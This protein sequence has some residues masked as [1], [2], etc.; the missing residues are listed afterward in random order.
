METKEQRRYLRAFDQMAWGL[1]EA[2]FTQAGQ[3]REV[4][5]EDA[6]EDFLNQLP[7]LPQLEKGHVWKEN[8]VESA[9]VL[10][11]HR[12]LRKYGFTVPEI[13]KVVEAYYEKLLR[14]QPMLFRLVMR[15]VASS[16]IFRRRMKKWAAVTQDRSCP[17]G[18]VF[19]YIPGDGKT[20]TYG[21]DVKECA[22]CK[23]YQAQGEE[24]LI[25]GV[26]RLDYVLDRVIGTGLVR[27]GTLGEG[28]S[29]CDFRFTRGV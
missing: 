26:C 10:A 8:L 13:E 11:L 21:L 2:L 27:T 6:R 28:Q 16:W 14:S 7:R 3:S 22:I 15:W 23:Y 18:W 25:P 4:V 9:M 19:E 29:R 12:T 5:L 17:D 1:P 24:A 20:F